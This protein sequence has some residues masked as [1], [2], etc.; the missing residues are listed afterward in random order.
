MVENTW[1]KGKGKTHAWV[2]AHV[3]YQGD[4]CLKWPFSVDPRV[5]RGMMGHNGEDYWAHRYMCELAHGHAP[6]GK[7]QAAHSC[8][9]GHKGCMNPRH[10]SWKSNSENQLDRRRHGTVI[11]SWRS[12]FTPERIAELR[13]LRGK[14]TQM[15]LA[16]QFGCS[17]GTVQYY[18]KYRQQRGHEPVGSL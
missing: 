10:L 11:E 9:N 5:G 6:E 16:E 1:N 15:Q 14:K 13:S 8:G 7:P 4:D 3:D 17:L 2:M 12:K 18:F